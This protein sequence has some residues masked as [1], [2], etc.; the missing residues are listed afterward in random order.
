MTVLVCSVQQKAA[1]TNLQHA[2]HVLFVHPFFELREEEMAKLEAQA[3]GRVQ[4]CGQKKQT[5]LHRFVSAHTIE[6]ELVVQRH[7]DR[8]RDYFNLLAANK[9]PATAGAATAGAATA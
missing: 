6:H 3:I 8:W 7:C 1:G 4:R 5:Y 9:T 2:N